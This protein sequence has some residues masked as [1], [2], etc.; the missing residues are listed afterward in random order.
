MISKAVSDTGEFS[1]AVPSEHFCTL[2]KY[3]EYFLKLIAF[4]CSLF[5]D[6]SADLLAKGV[7]LAV[8][9]SLPEE[10][11]NLKLYDSFISQCGHDYETLHHICS[12]ILFLN[13][14][15]VAEFGKL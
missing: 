11:K 14:N 6:E 10:C 12:Q 4:D 5:H 7:F 15:F 2:K 13:L 9:R 8:I 1:T 3:A